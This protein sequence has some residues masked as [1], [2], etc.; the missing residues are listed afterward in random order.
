MQSPQLRFLPVSGPAARDGGVRR[1]AFWDWSADPEAQG[2]HVVICVHGLSRQGRDFD[3]LAQALT[4]RSR[5]LAVDVAG[6]GY[7]DWL[8]DPM[9]Y[10]LGNYVA[11]LAALVLQQRAEAHDVAIDW[12]G[13]RMGRRIGM[14]F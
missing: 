5:V 2:R 1:M 7:S 4:P 10:Q 8:A 14:G 3:V 11:D 6:R 13:S 12:V 9:A